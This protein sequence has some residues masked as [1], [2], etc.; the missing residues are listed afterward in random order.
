[1]AGWEIHK[2]M[3]GVL[4]KLPAIHTPK[5]LSIALSEC[6]HRIEIE[7]SLVL[8]NDHERGISSLR[9]DLLLIP[10]HYSDSEV[11]TLYAQTLIYTVFTISWSLQ[12]DLI[13]YDQVT[14]LINFVSADINRFLNKLLSPNSGSPLD[15]ELKHLIMILNGIDLKR[16]FSEIHDP[17]LYF[18]ETF[19]SIHRPKDRKFR[20]VYYTPKE[21]ISTIIMQVHTILKEEF[22]LPLG[23]ADS[24]TW[25]ALSS[26]S[27]FSLDTDID[28]E[29]KFVKILDPATGT[30]SFLLQVI[31]VIYEVVQTELTGQNLDHSSA[32][33]KWCHYVSTELLPRLHGYEIS[34]TPYLIA[35]LR[36]GLWLSKSGFI[37]QEDETLNLKLV[38]ALEVSQHCQV[39]SRHKFS[40]II[41]NPPYSVNSSNMSQQL[42]NFIGRYRF[43]AEQKIQEKGALMFERVLQN[44][45]VK[46]IRL[47][48]ILSSSI[49]SIIGL[50]TSH[51]YLTGNYI[52][53]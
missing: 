3:I 12:G 19:L 9:S 1:M 52:E 21:V 32:H 33:A 35:H 42:K 44:D 37:F 45:Y 46:F 4:N 22:K 48:E 47:S 49:G 14:S 25:T 27:S 2:V 34:F 24:S 13:H 28:G 18:Y 17:I 53:V 7:V 43:F 30:G 29:S 26:R 51:S 50:V 39:S 16:V 8:K 6:A 10:H 31:E 41:G 36:L 40:V 15:Q 11:S 20:G 5:Q 23:L 38:N